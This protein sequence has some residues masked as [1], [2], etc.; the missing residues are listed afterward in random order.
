MTMRTV[1]RVS[2]AILVLVQTSHCAGLGLPGLEEIMARWQTYQANPT[3]L[4]IQPRKMMMSHRSSAVKAPP[5]SPAMKNMKTKEVKS[6]GMMS[7]SQKKDALK[8]LLYKSASGNDKSSKPD[9]K[10]QK[11]NI[12]PLAISLLQALKSQNPKPKP[13]PLYPKLPKAAPKP[14]PKHISRPGP[15]QRPS[16]TN[17]YPPPTKK[18]K[19]PMKINK[20]IKKSPTSFQNFSPP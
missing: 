4:R 18:N 9:D 14:H 20:T 10:K 12:K 15:A 16:K 7:Y 17:R 5:P 11:T 3:L 2:C 8:A 6:K 13:K 1:I 19:P